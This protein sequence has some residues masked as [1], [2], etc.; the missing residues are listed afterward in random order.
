MENKLSRRY[1]LARQIRRAIDSCPEGICFSNL[2]GRPILV[3]R[4]FNQ[5]LA[6]LTGHTVTNA[7]EAWEELERHRL[8]DPELQGAKT[9]NILICKTGEQIWQLQRR[10]L[11]A[12]AASV[13]EYTASDITE[14]YRSRLRLAEE[15]RLA[16]EFQARQRELLAQIV[17]T[18]LDQELLNA[19]LRIHD[20]FGRVLLMTGQALEAPERR[21]DSALRSAWADV[22]R[23]LENASFRSGERKPS[24]EAELVRV[25][26]LIG[27]RVKFQGEQ[28]RER[29]ALLLLYAAIRE[30]LTNAVRHAGADILWIHIQEE[31]VCW[32]VRIGSNGSPP[33]APIREGVGLSSLRQRLEREGAQMAYRYE[34]GLVLD[35][36]IPREEL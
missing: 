32:R 7:A 6:A 26:E 1:R 16:A 25:A 21:G 15:N 23:D 14:L 11:L 17:Q 13:V 4:S 20:S 24:P 2:Q 34:P 28:P 33:Q 5:L 29:R 9:G 8:P 18:N 35:L 27:C 31:A 12:E 36:T 3:N 19:K 22:I 10:E 30:A